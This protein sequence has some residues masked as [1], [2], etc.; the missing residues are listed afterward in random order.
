MKNSIFIIL[1]AIITIITFENCETSKVPISGDIGPNYI[2]Q[3]RLNEYEYIKNQYFLID[4]YYKSVFESSFDPPTMR[5]I[6]QDTR[7]KIVQLDVWINDRPTS[8]SSLPAWA[9]SDPTQI[10]PDSIDYLKQIPGQNVQRFFSRLDDGQYIY[11]EFRGYFW[12]DFP[13]RDTD[14][15]AIAYEN[16]AGEKFGMLWQDITY[17]AQIPLLKLIKAENMIPSYPTWPLL[18]QN[19]YSMGA[20]QIVLEGFDV[21]VMYT[22]TGHEILVQPVGDQKTFNYLTGLDRLTVNGEIL[23]GDD[24]IIDYINAN[25][26][27]IYHGLIMFPSLRPFDPRFC[28]QFKIDNSL[29]VEMYDTIDDTEILNQHK[30]DIE[31][32]I[33]DTFSINNNQP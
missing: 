8:A 24:G 5:W 19:V 9:V 22:G 18:M 33:L 29:S 25:I 26:F 13:V 7:K 4:F 2:L 12:L 14:V 23:E 31:I 27:D 32:S 16:A 1:F 21:K 28:Q 15:I 10:H 11:D 3:T 20:D 17:P 6:I 30:F